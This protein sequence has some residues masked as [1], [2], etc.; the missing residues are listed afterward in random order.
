[1]KQIFKDFKEGRD[2]KVE[3]GRYFKAINLLNELNRGP[4][5]RC[6]F[7]NVSFLILL[8]AILETVEITS[9]LP[10]PGHIY[11]PFRYR[12]CIMELKIHQL[13]A[14]FVKS[15]MPGWRNCAMH[16]RLKQTEK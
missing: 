12:L 9:L 14:Q 8:T 11:S 15:D 1:M 13:R 6:A 7:G 16:K 10:L 4:R 2:F 3:F 5:V